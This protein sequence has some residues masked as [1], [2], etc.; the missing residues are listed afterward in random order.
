[1]RVFQK[2]GYS[3]AFVVPANPNTDEQG[4]VKSNFG[5]LSNNWPNLT[6]VQRTAWNNA[7]VSG[8]FKIPDLKTGSSRNPKS[9]LEL[10]KSVNMYIATV[11]GNTGSEINTPPAAQ[12][13]GDTLL[14]SVT[15]DASAGTVSIAYSGTLG[16]H[17]VHVVRFAAPVSAGR[18]VLRPTLLRIVLNNNAAATPIAAGSAYTAKFGAITGLAG[19]KIFYRVDAYNSETGQTRLVG[20]GST[21]IVA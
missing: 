14:T 13:F 2:N 4:V 3:R 11:V 21:I 15:A 9:G 8:D 10:F 1:M 16:A 17:E 19:Q 20:Q 18:M 5:K 12:V 7:A 6:E